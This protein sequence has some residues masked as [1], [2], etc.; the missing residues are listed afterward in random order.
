MSSPR[1]STSL[2]ASTAQKRGYGAASLLPPAC[3]GDK[4]AA[5][6]AAESKDT[7]Q[8]LSY[9]SGRS[10]ELSADSER[11]QQEGRTRLSRLRPASIDTGQRPPVRALS[12]RAGKVRD[13]EAKKRFELWPG[14]HTFLCAGRVMLGSDPLHL[15]LSYILLTVSWGELLSCEWSECLEAIYNVL[16][17]FLLCCLLTFPLCC[18]AA[19]FTFCMCVPPARACTKLT[20]CVA[21]GG[22]EEG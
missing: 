9:Q 10:F 8:L 14:N 17:R 16:V 21:C 7:D 20:T 11:Q 1:P 13:A 15:A 22:L 4:D 2:Q 3:T 12:L 6:S 18:R 5:P 19:I